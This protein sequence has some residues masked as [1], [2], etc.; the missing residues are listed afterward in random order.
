MGDWTAAAVS[1]G[2]SPFSLQLL[3][4]LH[5][6]HR[7]EVAG[8]I[9]RGLDNRLSANDKQRLEE[10]R[11]QGGPSRNMLPIGIMPPH[12]KGEWGPS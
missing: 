8:Y 10:A 12:V 4:M 7:D 11:K 6:Y 5:Q 2:A 1:P 3:Q 9:N